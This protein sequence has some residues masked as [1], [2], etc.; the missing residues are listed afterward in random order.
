MSFFRPHKTKP[1][2]FNYIPRHYDPVKEERE[3]RRR[4]LHGTSTEDDEQ[5]YVPGKYIRTQR[6]ARDAAREGENAT[7][8]TKIRNTAIMAVMI[9]LF[10]L[11]IVPRFVDFFYMARDEREASME[12]QEMKRKQLEFIEYIEGVDGIENPKQLML[13]I[14]EKEA[15]QRR[16]ANISF[17]GEQDRDLKFEI[18]TI[19]SEDMADADSEAINAEY[20]K[21]IKDPEQWLKDRAKKESNQLSVKE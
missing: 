17:E 13:S 8:N 20:Q 5:E 16:N 9:C 14:D 12:E 7:R 10:A 1:R 6:E 4:E 21:A 2:Q 18:F 15:W 3:Q 11:I 19:I